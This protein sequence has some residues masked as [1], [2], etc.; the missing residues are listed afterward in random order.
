MNWLKNNWKW[1]VPC[2]VVLIIFLFL[3]FTL[4]I[5][6]TEAYKITLNRAQSNSALIEKIGQPIDPGF[7]VI[8]SVR[9][10]VDSG[11]T[12]LSFSVEGPHGTA[13][14]HSVAK[15]LNGT[16]F[17]DVLEAN[18]VNHGKLNL[19]QEGDR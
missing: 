5:K 8:G 3:G 15:K 9:W 6:S 18:I 14:I 2:L 12:S 17:F 13:S 11:W 10:T 4:L 7:F 1:F 16:W 19:L